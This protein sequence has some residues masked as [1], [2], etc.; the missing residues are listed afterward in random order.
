MRVEGCKC[1]CH[2]RVRDFLHVHSIDIVLV[3]LLQDQI[4]FLPGSIV[5]IQLVMLVDD[6]ERQHCSKHTEHNSEH[7][8]ERAHLIFSSHL[9]HD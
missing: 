2:S 6:I 5:G 8:A 3:H 4:Q 1:R 9:I 7:R